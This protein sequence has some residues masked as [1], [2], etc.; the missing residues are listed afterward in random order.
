MEG[1]A[2]GMGYAF[3]DLEDA[4]FERLVVQ[5]MRKLFGAGVQGFAPG[6]DGGRDARFEGTAAHFPSEAAPW[7]GI[8]IGQAKHTAAVNAHYNETS[9][10]GDGKSSV[11]SKE[12]ERLKKL[13]AAGELDNYILFSNRRLGG[14]VGP[15][16]QKRIAT[17][18]GLPT[19]SVHLVGV[20]R[21]NE[22]LVE[23]PDVLELARIDPVDSPLLPSS[24]DLSEVV[25]AIADELE[26]AADT[27]GPAERV[28]YDT[29]N[30]A[31]RMSPEFAAELSKR[32]L[33][34]TRRIDDF[35]AAP[36]NEPI[37]RRYEATVED[38][39][40]KIIA[41]RQDYQSFDDVFNY[42]VEILVKRDPALAGRAK[43]VRIMLFYMYWS[44]DI[45]EQP[46]AAA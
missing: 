13:K 7:T 6:K 24:E 5:C 20:E 36:E 2:R 16:L 27:L 10:S 25:L 31:N 45:G 33:G 15:A 41:K 35:F 40:L 4:Q 18:V 30:E 9:F 37:L 46:D 19:A 44:C 26:P 11:L 23:H 43:L 42:L 39:Q 8:T 21:L 14:V 1:Y 22:L 38:F 29:K 28:A 17:D 34:Y 12:I 3:E 32:Y